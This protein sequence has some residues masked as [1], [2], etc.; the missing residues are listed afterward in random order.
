MSTKWKQAFY[1]EVEPIRLKDPLAVFLGAI[2]ENEEFIFTYEDAVKLAGHSCPA[3]SG[4][5][6]ITQKALHALYGNETPLRGGLSVR[7][8][9]SIDNGANGPIS[10]V[11]SLI[12]GAAPETGFAGLGNSFIRKNKLIFDEKNEEANAFVFTRDDNKKSVKVTYHPE[13]VPADE[14]MHELFTKCIVGTANEKQKERFKEM[15]QKR[16][17]CVL[18]E[19]AKG[20]FTVEKLD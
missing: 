3:V 7:V 2:D 17:R 4:A 10:Q 16:V 9:G 1:D 20:L 18:F 5:Y 8:L 13:N 15:W 12:T 19:E 11:I 14:D 6:K